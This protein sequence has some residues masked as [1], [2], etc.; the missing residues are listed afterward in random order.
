MKLPWMVP[1]SLTLIGL[2]MAPAATAQISNGTG[3]VSVS[4]DSLEVVDSKNLAIYKGHVD[5][6]QDD[7]RLQAKRIE[8]QFEGNS[9]A[10]NSRPGSGF[11][12]FKTITAIGNVFYSTPKQV[13]RGNRAVYKAADD[14]ITMTGNVVL[15]QD[16]NVI[17]ADSLQIDRKTGDARFKANGVGRTSKDRVRSVFFPSKEKN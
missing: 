4:A 11:G 15:T 3:P 10:A 17:R 14:T 6:T 1:A 8:V 5:V 9:G 13:V 2:A 12:G 7:S 16:T